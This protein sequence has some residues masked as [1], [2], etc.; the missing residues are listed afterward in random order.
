MTVIFPSGAVGLQKS[1]EPAYKKYT[2]TNSDV[3]KVNSL[4]SSSVSVRSDN[5][6][7]YLKFDSNEQLTQTVVDTSSFSVQSK[8][9]YFLVQSAG[10]VSEIYAPAK[11]VNFQPSGAAKLVTYYSVAPNETIELV[12]PKNYRVDYKLSGTLE[13]LKFKA[14]GEER[15]TSPNLSSGNFY[16][17]ANEKALMTNSGTT[18]VN[19]QVPYQHG[20]VSNSEV[21][22]FEKFEVPANSSLTLD[23]TVDRTQFVLQGTE[24]EVTIFENAVKKSSR[25]YKGRQSIIIRDNEKV[26]L[27][28]LTNDLLTVTANHGDLKKGNDI[29]LSHPTRLLAKFYSE[30][31][32]PEFND[33]YGNFNSAGGIYVGSE[34]VVPEQVLLG[35]PN[36]NSMVSLPT[37]SFVVLGYDQPLIDLPNEPDLFIE[38][39]GKNPVEEASVTGITISGKRVDLGII[40]SGISNAIDFAHYG[41]KEPIIAV[42]IVGLDDNGLS[43]GYDVVMA[44]GY[45]SNE[46]YLSTNEKEALF[47]EISSEFEALTNP[48]AHKDMISGLPAADK[49]GIALRSEIAIYSHFSDP[50][51]T[52]S[53]AQVLD[54][55]LVTLKGARELALQM[56]YNSLL[57]NDTMF[58]KAWY[59]NFSTRLELKSEDELIVHWTPYQLENFKKKSENVYEGKTASIIKENGQ[60]IVKTK[61]LEQYIFNS[62]GQLIEQLDAQRKTLQLTY[63][64]KNQLIK[65]SDPLSDVYVEFMYDVN[66]N[67]SNI[68]D[69]SNRRATFTYDNKN[70]LATIRTLE[71]QHIVFTHNLQGQILSNETDG[72]RI[73]RNVFDGIGRVIYQD[74]GRSDNNL[75]EFRYTE[76]VDDK[77]LETVATN[78][79]GEKYTFIHNEKYQLIEEITPLGHKKIYSYDAAGN[80]KSITDELGRKTT[81]SYN[82]LGQIET[83]TNPV[84]NKEVYHYDSSGNVIKVTMPDGSEWSATYTKEGNLETYTDLEGRTTNFAYTS[85]GLLE[86]AS[87]EDKNIHYTYEDGRIKTIKDFKNSVTNFLYDEAGRVVQVNVDGIVTK[88]TYNSADQITSI[89]DAKGNVQKFKYDKHQNLIEIIDAEGNIVETNTYNEN[90][91]LVKSKNAFGGITTYVYDAEDRLIEVLDPNGASTT[92]SYDAANN[93][94]SVKSPDGSSST[95]KIDAVGNILEVTDYKGQT[96][97]TKTLDELDQITKLVDALGNVTTY[98]F[99]EVGILKGTVDA[100]KRS[101]SFVNDAKQ[102]LQQQ[103]H[104]DGTVVTRHYND[105]GFVTAVMDENKNKTTFN[106]DE[107]NLLLSVKNSK[108]FG[109]EFT[110]NHLSQMVEKMNERG[111]KS[112]YSYDANGNVTKIST[113]DETINYTYNKNNAITAIQNATSSIQLDYNKANGLEA[114]TDTKGNKIA[115]TY[116][117]K[118]ELAT[119]TY[120]DGKKVSYQYTADGFISK[121]TDWNNKVTSYE[122]DANGNIEKITYPNNTYELRQYNKAN[123]LVSIEVYKQNGEKLVS[124]QYSYD[125][126]GRTISVKS[127]LESKLSFNPFSISLGIGLN[128][129]LVRYDGASSIKYDK[130]GNVVK[131]PT[132]NTISTFKYNS[133]NVMTQAGNDKLHY[134]LLGNLV[135][136]ESPKTTIDLTINPNAQYSQLLVEEHAQGKRHYVYGAGLLGYYDEKGEYTNYYFDAVGN[137]MALANASGSITDTYQ[138]SPFGKILQHEGNT[139]QPF[140]YSGQYGVYQLSNG[141]H[142]MRARYYNGDLSRFMTIDPYAGKYNDLALLNVYAYGNNNPMLYVDPDGEWAFLIPLGKMAVSGLVNVAVTAAF[143]GDEM[144]WGKAGSAFVAGAIAGPAGNGAKAVANVGKAINNSKKAGNAIEI[145]AGAFAGGFTQATLDE[146]DNAVNLNKGF[147]VEQLLVNG[148]KNTI[149]NVGWGLASKGVSS[150]FSKVMPDVNSKYFITTPEIAGGFGYAGTTLSMNGILSL[151]DKSGNVYDYKLTTPELR[152]TLK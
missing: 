14:N 80:V 100:L 119:M 96:M 97:M 138:Y 115:Y 73:F 69:S 35:E 82:E 116:T 13:T 9:E 30:G 15:D 135:K 47:K 111:Q 67:I 52:A 63:N 137:T 99:D 19:V 126:V 86:V 32:N 109:A 77:T 134:D 139:D 22:A 17:Y 25:T 117:V 39:S 23:K 91:K 98:E 43:P 36:R 114:Y 16:L 150:G 102:N 4:H 42:G 31:I 79:I 148:T 61:K 120:P 130:D 132:N 108:G 133:E 151:F 85:D 145:G 72:K 48:E 92:Y 121:V 75:V 64:E 152:A 8:N 144:T 7:N 78:R 18:I 24:Y 127:S 45:T 87:R 94:V 49:Y 71:G 54:L 107:G 60:F 90:N 57:L 62:K 118:G 40:Q 34:Y 46:S 110:Y 89:T 136:I 83:V 76:N 33:F 149:G 103:K 81:Y 21:S 140:N 74:D 124:K 53:G 5:K 68:N 56:S 106:Y 37:G 129:E 29:L 28:N 101:T 112:T 44:S 66:N 84:G 128:N 12:N 142:Y 27:K 50:I 65:I 93:L 1:P 143:A 123:Q 131:A 38:E 147:S 104:P 95:Y 59:H 6:I 88:Y 10:T 3:V 11:H 141:L 122:Y 105:D 51:D 41:V 113:P 146:V 26:V 20:N 58:G 125:A 55:P 2:V 70:N